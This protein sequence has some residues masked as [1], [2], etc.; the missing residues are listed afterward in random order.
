MDFVNALGPGLFHED[1]VA[2]E[3]QSEDSLLAPLDVM[4]FPEEGQ[5]G[6]ARH[7][8]CCRGR[9]FEGVAR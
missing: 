7:T 1:Y 2:L 3:P 4:S 9:A 5:E 8:R 6:S